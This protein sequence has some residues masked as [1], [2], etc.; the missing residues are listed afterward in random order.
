MDSLTGPTVTST[1]E[2]ARNAVL[3]NRAQELEA[4]FLAEMLR[5]TGLG[6]PPESFGGGSGEDQFS[7]FLRQEQATAIARR[8]GI[9]LS[10]HLFN[11]MKARDNVSR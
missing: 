8:G 1:T 7:S 2:A 4:Q 6:R 5:H 3:R 11:A 10:E 9:G